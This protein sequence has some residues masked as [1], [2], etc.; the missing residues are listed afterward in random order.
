M[1]EIVLNN[2]EVERVRNQISRKKIYEILEVTPKTY[3]NYLHGL[4]IPSSKLL[5][6]SKLFN[7][8]IDYLLSI[9]PATE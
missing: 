4:P 7:C 1:K 6:L 3:Y 8:T 5:K 2:I 9:A